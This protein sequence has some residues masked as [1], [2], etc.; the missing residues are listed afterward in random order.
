[1]TYCQDP[2]YPP[3]V[4]IPGFTVYACYNDSGPAIAPTLRYRPR[5]AQNDCYI[6][7]CLIS[8]LVLWYVIVPTVVGVILIAFGLWLYCCCSRRSKESR[9][10]WRIKDEKDLE[11]YE[12]LFANTAYWK[13]IGEEYQNPL[14]VTG[15]LERV[16]EL[17]EER[18][19]LGRGERAATR[20]VRWPSPAAPR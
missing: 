9:E 1:M 16:T 3:A 18:C 11:P 12:R 15:T 10:A 6:D 2:F 20:S 17:L 19:H 5:C 13:R 7:Q 8:G 4:D 14:I